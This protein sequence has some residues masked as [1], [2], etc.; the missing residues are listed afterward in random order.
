MRRH[1]IRLAAVLCLAMLAACG[2]KQAKAPALNTLTRV[3]FN[4]ATAQRFLPLF[5][6]EDLNSDGTLQ[7]TELAVL[8]GLPDDDAALWIDD[9]GAFTP[10]FLETYQSLSTPAATPPDARQQAVLAELAQSAPTLVYTDLSQD[11]PG[12]RQ[13][14]AHLQSAAKG[15]ERLYARQNGV[16]GMAEKIPADDLASRAMFHRNQSPFCE[17]PQTENDPNCVALLPRPARISGLYPAAIQETPGFCQRLEKEPN[18]AA[19][20]EDHFSIVADDPAKPGRFI[21]VPYPQAWA[22]DMQSV[23]KDLNAAADALGTTETAFVAYLRAAA[24]A[25]GTNDWEP[26]NRA[27]K[28]MNATNSKWFSRVAPDEV[29]YDP[30]A[31][32]AGFALQLARI[33]PDSIQWQQKLEPLKKEMEQKLAA[34]AGAPYKARDVNFSLPDFIDVVLNAGDQRSASGATIGQSLPNWGPVAASGGRTVAMTN[35]YTDADSIARR[36]E[37]HSAVLCKATFDSYPSSNKETVFNSLLHEAAH[38]LGPS[39]DYAVAGKTGPQA[40][41]GPLASTLEELKAQNSA[42]YLTTFLFEKGIFTDEDRKKILREDIT[43]AFGHIS[44]GMY[45]ASGTPRNYSQLAA[46]QIGSFLEAGALAWHADELAA[47]GKDKGCMSVDY[48]KLPAAVEKL[49]KQVLGIKARADR[50]AAEA[51][52]AKHVDAKDQFADIRAAI[53]ERYLRVPKANFVYSIAVPR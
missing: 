11:S 46:I 33:N 30:C 24:E 42:L 25:F 5:W 16:F 20:M 47:N 40:F 27:W 3:Q 17:G 49:E 2:Q 14:V 41:G 19:L 31:W 39:H 50:K 53:A 48:D 4:D 10:R 44:R 43:W 9:K 52:K 21:T 34:L 6:R 15:I 37:Q 38:N 36:D 28:A 18:A 32:K 13:M 1:P 8:W 22:E 26:A 12:E 23:A 51:L 7:P 45:E 35:L 29:Y